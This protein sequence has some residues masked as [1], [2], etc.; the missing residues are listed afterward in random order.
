MKNLTFFLTFLCLTLLL[1]CNKADD[2]LALHTLMFKVDGVDVSVVGIDN[3]TAGHYAIGIEISGDNGFQGVFF[4]I[5]NSAT[6]GTYTFNNQYVGYYN[7]DLDTYTTKKEGGG[8]T[9]TVEEIDALHISGTF[10]YTTYDEIT[11]AKKRSIT[12]GRFN[13]AF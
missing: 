12:K 2:G 3:V 13:A 6:V 11:G 5:P 4:Y 1:S 9:V 10:E 8:G 7:E